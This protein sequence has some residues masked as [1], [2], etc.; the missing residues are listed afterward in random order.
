MV[1]SASASI[2][3]LIL[4]MLASTTIEGSRI[5]ISAPFGTKSHKNM[6]VPLVKELVSRGHNI[7]V[8]TNYFTADFMDVENVREIVLEKLTVDMSQYPN[9]FDSLL[10][11]SNWNWGTSHL[12][13]LTMFKYPRLVTEVLYEDHRVQEMMANERFNLVI[14]S[15]MVSTA[16]APLAWH[17]KAPLMVF[18][19]NTLFPGMATILGDDE[20]TSYVPFMFT[21][22]TDQMNLGQRI[23]NTLVTK[24]CTFLQQW[25]EE[26]TVPSIVK[27]KGIAGCPS[28][29]NIIKNVTM[30]FT[31]SHPS[32]T[33][34]R[35]LPPQVIEVG[36]I[37][38]RPAKS[39]SKDLET[40]LS[41]ST[42]KGFLLFSV[43]S[44]QR[45]EDMPERVIQSFIR[46]FA[47]LPVRVIWQWK[48]KTRTDLPSNVLAIPWLPQQ[49]LL[50]KQIKK[51][52]ITFLLIK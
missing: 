23:A 31:N 51:I 3:F 9:A 33:Y 30:V 32:F 44:L 7:T 8:I 28:I 37:H 11:S 39:L 13:L 34:S 52:V 1:K 49:D 43:G 38:C 15:Q 18:S 48:G 46:T 27:E 41:G 40:F 22:F 45:M 25:Y 42:D 29:Q 26:I 16:S 50:G 24:L 35:S 2:L 4:M 20:H 19:P 12:L 5:L 17:F 36:G 10:S 21:H 47:R 14:V 6:Y